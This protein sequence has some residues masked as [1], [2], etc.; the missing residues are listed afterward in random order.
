MTY[1]LAAFQAKLR[2]ADEHLGALVDGIGAF[3]ETQ[4]Y[5]IAFEVDAETGQKVARAKAN[6]EPPPIVDWGLL[7]GDCVHNMRSALDHLAWE[8]SGPEPPEQTEFPI[9]H[10]REKFERASRR[11]GLWKIEGIKDPEARALIESVQPCYSDRKRPETH[12]LA[13]LRDFAN[14]DKH[15]VLHLSVIG[16]G[17]MSYWVGESGHDFI[18]SVNFGPLEDGTEIG[19]FTPRPEEPEQVDMNVSFSLDVTMSDRGPARNMSAEG[20]M[21]R[22]RETI[23]VDIE[24]PAR[25]LWDPTYPQGG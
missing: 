12:P 10:E 4:P 13:S 14:I 18:N 16:L 23:R 21:R 25:K 2:R 20:A 1:S 19:R 9:F 22:I 3:L 11:G 5:L 24:T 17:G 15:R 7:I 8:L 6:G